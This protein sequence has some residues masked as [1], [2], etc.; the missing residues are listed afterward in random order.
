MNHIKKYKKMLDSGDFSPVHRWS[1]RLEKAGRS[2]YWFC[3]TF[4]IQPASFS[5]WVNG[6]N[7]PNMGNFIEVEML[8]SQIEGGK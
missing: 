6:K 2:A 8:L 5:R 1:I 4:S 3:N 7:K